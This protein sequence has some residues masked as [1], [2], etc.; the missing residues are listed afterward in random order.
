VAAASMKYFKRD[1]RTLGM[2]IPDDQ[3]QRAE[4]PAAPTVAEVMK[5]FKPI[6][7]VSNGE[8]FDPSQ[9]NIE[10]RT[11]LHKIGGLQ[12]ALLSKR[13]RG[14][15]VSVALQLHWGDEKNLF[16]KQTISN[17]TGEMLMRGNRDFTRQQL[18]DEFEK[19]KIAGDL[20]HFQTTR[21]N[22]AAALRLVAKILREP[23]FPEAEFEQMRSQMLVT[24]EST[25]SDPHVLVEQ[26]IGAH[27]NQYPLGDWRANQ[28]LDEQIA[29]VKAAKLDDIKAFYKEFYGTSH[30]ELAIVGD[31]DEPAIVRVLDETLTN[32]NSA[33]AYSIVKRSYADIAPMHKNIDARDKENGFYTARVNLDLADDDADYPA[34]TLANYI[35]G[36]GAGLDSRLMTRIRKKDGLSY[37][38]ESSLEAGLVDRAGSFSIGAIAAPQNLAKLD[39]AVREELQRTLKNGFTADEVARAKSGMLQQRTQTRAQDGALAYGWT[40]YL[41]LGRTYAWSKA[42][43]DKISALSAEQVSAAFRKAIDPAKL[44]VVIAGDAKKAAP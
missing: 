28:T 31:F 4:I 42:Y 26:E 25:R 5:D 20:Y 22:L 34:L 24:L 41:Y 16:G 6:Q 44:T 14:E 3:P 19:L 30:G 17:L 9:A 18:A 7:Q 40:T 10:A 43:E 33:A 39:A 2:F 37:G 29:E 35:F 11:K 12:V 13:N 38:G 36:G 32:W 15:T 21:S 8:A 23:S 1:N 27:F